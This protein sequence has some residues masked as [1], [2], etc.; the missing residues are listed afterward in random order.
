MEVTTEHLRLREFE[1]SDFEPMLVYQSDPRYLRFYEREWAD[2]EHRVENTR[3]LLQKFL[4]SQKEQPRTK[5]QLAITLPDEGRLIGSVGIRIKSA[6][7]TEGD[8]GYELAPEYWNRGYAT[9]AAR[10]MVDFG[11][12]ELGLHRV[13]SYTVAG[14]TGSRRVMEKLGMTLEGE[15]R[16]TTLLADGWANTVVY[17]ILEQEWRVKGNK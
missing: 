13:W 2:P 6:D 15:L 9:E 7:A 17:G 8:I 10:A 3:K 5:F 14:N 1:E 4:D 16:E 12:D 11:F